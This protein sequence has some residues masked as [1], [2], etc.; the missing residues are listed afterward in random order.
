M[1]HVEERRTAR[2]SRPS[3]FHRC[4]GE[5]SA[6]TDDRRNG[7]VDGPVAVISHTFWQRHYGAAP[8]VIGRSLM[9]DG[10]SVTVVG[11]T[12]Q[13]FSGLDVGRRADVIVPFGAA[14]LMP[15]HEDL[16]ITIMARR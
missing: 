7:G 13:R 2:T 4:L 6:E 9:L 1:G 8:D 11:V 14:T 10:A 12:P 5:C 15:G 3:V 16:Q